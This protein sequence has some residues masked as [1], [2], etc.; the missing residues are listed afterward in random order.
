MLEKETGVME[1][2][3]EFVFLALALVV[4]FASLCLDACGIL[5]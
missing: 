2:P 5:R 1:L 3:T 4:S